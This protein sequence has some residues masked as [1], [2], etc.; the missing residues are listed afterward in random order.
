MPGCGLIG[1]GAVLFVLMVAFPER[2]NVPAP[3][4][5]LVAAAFVLA[6]FL[7][8]ANVFLD[9]RVSNWLAVALLSCM[10]I[11]SAW[12]AV[13]PGERSCAGSFGGFFYFT[14][15][16]ACRVAFGIGAVLGLVFIVIAFRYALR[17]DEDEDEG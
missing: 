9:R 5:Y 3:I 4:G 6:G 16:G 17:R 15:G 14:E 8:L 12:I 1:L 11:P 7:A 13:G 10:V 2:L